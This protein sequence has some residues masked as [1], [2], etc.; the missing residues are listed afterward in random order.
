VSL[1]PTDVSQFVRLEQCGRYLRLRL[2]ERLAGRHFLQE[3]DVAPQAIT[4]LLT[5]AGRAFEERVGERLRLRYPVTDLGPPDAEADRD[6]DNE[7]VLEMA[8]GLGPGEVRVLLQPRLRVDLDGWL[9]TGDPD[10]VRLERA[11]DGALEILIADMKSASR[12]KVEHRLQLAFYAAMMLR[13]LEGAG[14]EGRRLRTAVLYPG[15]AHADEPESE[16]DRLR[17]E[18]EQAAACTLFGLDAERL[19]LCEEPEAYHD[20]VV[21][22]V[23]GSD[24][25]ARRVL[26][27]PFS[28]IPYHLS[29]KCDGCLYNEFC[30]K[31]SAEQDDLSLIPYLSVAEKK[32]LRRLG[33]AS[34][35]DLAG[36]K[37]LRRGAEGERGELTPVPAT[38]AL[39]RQAATTWPVGHRL[40]ELIHRARRY[41]KWRGEALE[42]LPE[43]PGA[44]HGSLPYC[45][46]AQNPNL[47][48]VYIDAQHDY[49]HDRI[50]LLGALVVGCEAGEPRRRESV[51]HLAEGPPDGA[52][53]ERELLTRW[54]HD[55]LRA[56]VACAAPDASG[57]PRAPVHLIFFNRFEQKMLLEALSRHLGAILGAAPALYDFMTQLAAFDSPIASFLDEEIRERKNYPMVCQSLQAVAGYLRF[58]WDEGVPFTRHFR[59][60]LFDQWRKE[61]GTEEAPRWYAG[62]A[63]FSSQIPLEYAYAAWGELDGDRGIERR[64]GDQDTRR[65]PYAAFRGATVDL[66]QQFQARRLEAMEHVAADFPGNRLTEKRPFD[67]PDLATYTD[68]ARSLAQ[69]LH[70]FVLIERHVE[71]HDW[72]MIRHAPPERRVLMGET[73]LV[74]YR[75]E[76]QEPGVAETIR[77]HARRQRLRAEYEASFRQA[78][79]DAASVELTKE[80]KE[81]TRVAPEGLRVRLRLETE[82]LDG[83][84][85]EILARFTLKER[86]QFVLFPRWTVDGRLPVAEQT[87]FTPTPK[88]MLYG[89]RAELV[90]PQL[91]RDAAGKI[92]EGW[93]EVTLREVFAGGK[94][95][96]KGFVFGTYPPRSLAP[97]VSLTL[98]PC[99]N[100]WLGSWTAGLMQALCTAEEEGLGRANTL[101]ARLRDGG[102]G[103]VTWPAAAA[104]GQARFLAGLEALHAAGALHD[105]EASKREY[106]AGH[107]EAPILLVQGP[108]GTGKSYATA[109]ALFARMQGAMAAGRPFRVL[110]ACKTHA[111]TDVLLQ[112]V[113]DV[114]EVL[115]VIRDADPDCFE[116]SIDPRLLDVPLYRLAGEES[117][118]EGV[119]S[120][121]KKSEKGQPKNAERLTR[122]Q[123]CVAAATP[124][125][126]YRVVKEKWGKDLLG[127]HFCDCLV[128]DEASQMSLPEAVMAAL[129]LCGDGQLIVV[130]D[131][132]QMPPIVK[133]DWAGEPRRTFREYRAYESLF[134][135]LRALSP[136]HGLKPV[137]IIR[138]EESFRLHAA[139]ASFLRQEIYEKDGIRFHSRRHDLLPPLVHAEPFLAAVLNREHPLVVIVHDEAESQK[140][141]PFEQTLLAPIL[142]A[143]ADP[144]RYGL[145]AD[146]GLG[147]VVPHRAQRAAFQSAFP[148]LSVFD[149]SG[150]LLRSAVDTV[151]RFQGDERRVILVSATESD[152]DYLL[153]ASEF[154]LD[155]RRLTVAMSRAKQKLILVAS[156]SVFSLFSPEEE[157]FA[158]AQLW[159]N[160]LRRTCTVKLWEGEQGGKRVEVWGNPPAA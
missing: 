149:A 80:Q 16:E 156:R 50:Y 46:A 96:P 146:H 28:Q 3:Y 95:G 99:P 11:G 134:E 84:L 128:L 26:R 139:M 55:L 121:P 75:E 66:L 141:N 150:V 89:L 147:V 32:A 20:S 115:R 2:Q 24:S 110:L 69:A 51:V 63:R 133:H 98:D 114:R 118:P 76:D 119:I 6:P 54:V 65:D 44:G 8:R 21:D 83:D 34:T 88:Q 92:A 62:R 43:I 60:H 77:D 130:G 94:E 117:P 104:E 56:I 85:E 97:G 41:R 129:P 111:A 81:E 159:K 116:A 35:R 23:T 39:C 93:L 101:Y 160:L 33:I 18:R 123:W 10:I 138:F 127:H 38:V 73:L 148:C 108:P 4:P 105:F 57:A 124:G 37:E 82:G 151:E 12:V 153:A 154:L 36:L 109:F 5:R 125:G 126:I 25:L 9:L 157:T 87:P 61:D 106:I 135:T 40:D 1:S 19:E 132:R 31:W 120:L 107:G 102:A 86:G 113:R 144:G 136:F 72:K 103:E 64:S 158:N 142:E 68:T 100:N 137:A 155:P 91:E 67:L 58:P 122:E 74:R 140:R 90:R 15:P 70:E 13:L 7:R 52:E 79:P 29:Y 53:R 131:H 14:I 30:M 152:R 45:D 49:L 143:L 17:R 59:A 27:T 78:N 47:V 42:A 22:L 112:N 48:R 71:L 145:D